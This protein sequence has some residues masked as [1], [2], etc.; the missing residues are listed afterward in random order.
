MDEES[1]VCY[2]EG[3]MIWSLRED[4][5]RKVKALGEVILSLH[6]FLEYRERY[7]EI[8]QMKP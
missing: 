7:D 8:K 4:C 6:S 2:V 1:A 5:E 3:Y